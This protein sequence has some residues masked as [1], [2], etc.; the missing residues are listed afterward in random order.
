MMTGAHLGFRAAGICL[1]AL[2]AAGQQISYEELKTANGVLEGVI[3]ADGKV[4]TFKGADHSG[5]QVMHFRGDAGATPDAQR[6]GYL[7]LDR[8]ASRVQ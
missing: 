6:D 7:F 8:M 5:A 3:S 1:V 2:S 4:R